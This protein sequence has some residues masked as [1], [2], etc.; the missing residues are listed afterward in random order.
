M[1]AD[2]PGRYRGELGEWALV[3]HHMGVSING[4]TPKHPK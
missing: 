1:D 2:S 3:D 4:G